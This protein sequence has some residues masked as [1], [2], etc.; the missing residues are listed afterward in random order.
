MGSIPVVGFDFIVSGRRPGT[1]K[2]TLRSLG[3]GGMDFARPKLPPSPF[4]LR[5]TSRGRDCLVYVRSSRLRPSGYGG[6]AA[7]MV[8]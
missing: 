4:G 6:Q 2:S 1:I 8:V 7:D 3:D 5:R